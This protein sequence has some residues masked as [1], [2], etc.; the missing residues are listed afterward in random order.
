MELRTFMARCVSGVLIN[1]GLLTHS[2]WTRN[3]SMM[4]SS[5][6]VQSTHSCLLFLNFSAQTW[7]VVF[8]TVVQTSWWSLWDK[9]GS[10]HVRGFHSTKYPMLHEALSG[11]RE[12]QSWVNFWEKKQSFFD[13]PP[14][15]SSI[16]HL[17]D[18]L[19][20]SRGCL[21]PQE[22]WGSATPLTEC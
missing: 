11:R 16:S 22:P 6:G 10:Q 17:W 5:A 20:C 13:F 8:W 18:T 12:H 2:C 19:L 21:P 9:L 14:H 15:N 7:P 1:C 4:V 3:L